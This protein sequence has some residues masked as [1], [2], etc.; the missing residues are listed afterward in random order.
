VDKWFLCN[1]TSLTSVD[2]SGLASLQTVGNGFLGNARSLT[3]AKIRTSAQSSAI[4]RA[5]ADAG[6]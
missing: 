6:F 3:T 4:A 2:L 1:A 5:L